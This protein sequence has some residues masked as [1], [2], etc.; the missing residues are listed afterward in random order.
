MTPARPGDVTQAVPW[1]WRSPAEFR[2]TLA[3]AAAR[4]GRVFRTLRVRR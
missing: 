4:A 2:W 3:M 1:Q